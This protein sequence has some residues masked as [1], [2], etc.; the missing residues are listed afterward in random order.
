[1]KRLNGRLRDEHAIKQIRIDWR[2]VS[3]RRSVRQPNRQLKQTRLVN[4]AEQRVRLGV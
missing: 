1:M 2:Q 3:N 4:D